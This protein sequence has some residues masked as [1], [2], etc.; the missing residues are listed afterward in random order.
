MLD[1][2]AIK[3]ACTNVVIASNCLENKKEQYFVQT[4]CRH[5]ESCGLRMS[6]SRYVEHLP[7]T[8]NTLTR[9][10]LCLQYCVEPPIYILSLPKPGPAKRNNTV[11]LPPK[12]HP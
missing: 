10:G 1:V 11:A 3:S 4:F 8:K 2:W 6:A 7:K 9:V 5:V 12:P